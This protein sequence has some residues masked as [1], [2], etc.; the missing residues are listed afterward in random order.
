[1]ADGVFMT[2]AQQIKFGDE[3]GDDLLTDIPYEVSTWAKDKG[4][5]V[6][7]GYTMCRKFALKHIEKSD[8]RKAQ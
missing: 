3:F 2:E 6:K 1:M 5:E 4:I 7:D 8:R